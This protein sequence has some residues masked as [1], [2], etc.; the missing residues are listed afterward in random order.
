MNLEESKDK[1]WIVE[2]IP[3]ELKAL[4]IWVGFKFIPQAG[5]K[6]KKEPINVATG[7]HAKSNDPK[8]W[9]TFD[10][11][12]AKTDMLKLNAIGIA[13]I[14][15]YIVCDIDHSVRDR[16]PSLLAKKIISAFPSYAEFSPSKTGIH[17]VG[18]GKI[19]R[20]RKFTT[21]DVEMY[22][23]TRFFTFTGDLVPGCSSEIREV[24]ISK[25]YDE[26]VALDDANKK[27]DSLFKRIKKSNDN[28]Q[29]FTL[30]EGK[31]QELYPSQSEADLAFCNKLAFWTGKDPEFMESLFR[32]SGLM[33]TKWDEKHFSD[34]RTYGQSLI[35][36][37]IQDTA[38][39]F[40]ESK[41][42]KQK[43][44]TQGEII[45]RDCEETITE[46]LRDQQGNPYVVLPFDK[47]LEVCTTSS[48]RFRNCF[49]IRYRQNYGHPP[50]NEALKQAR[51][52]VEAK[53]ENGRQVELYNR[54]GWHN[55]AIYYDL[56]TYD[57][58]GVAITKDGWEIVCLPPI[59]KRYPHQAEQALPIKG[60]DP[61]K[62]MDFCNMN[63]DDA[64]LFMTV[65]ASFFIPD[66]PHVI[67]AQVGEQGTG[68]SNNSRMIKSLCDPSKVMSISP[69]KDLEQAQ[70]IAD[71]H[72]VNN[73]DNLSRISEWFSDFLCRAVTGEGDMKRS[74]YTNDEEFIRTYRR[75]FVLNGI[76]SSVC[77]PDLL[78][79]SVIFDI[80]VLKE[81]RPEKQIADEW[82][83][84][85]PGILGGFFTA[86]SNAMAVIHSVSGHERF[87]MSDFAKWGAVLAEALGYSRD[88]FFKKYQESVDHKWEDTAE[89]STFAQRLAYLVESNSGEW[90]GSATTLL[91]SIQSESGFDKTIPSNP[92]ALGAELM[93]I[94]PV[95]RSI[96]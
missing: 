2:N 68:K 46:F 79:R 35:E 77:R 12:V 8:T 14:E 17:L 56:T 94:A 27:K 95:M 43:K 7:G 75:C 55:S 40:G 45:T 96:G 18:K 61:R 76:G 44:L 15:P 1:K 59:F 71:K 72:W 36:K 70:M 37:A 62:L 39:E 4:P 78:D 93:R 47:H 13:V 73:F 5:K 48:S 10:E 84:S 53:C 24:D 3:Q 60:G 90:I 49:A 92:R 63:K 26:L 74:L 6:P 33:R 19:P 20:D 22:S 57:W 66:I 86:I 42:A 89:E 65:V 38:N 64:C 80:P 91:K 50:G 32:K 31:W 16:I 51:I 30:Y 85:L 58:R 23:G 34:G 52:Q 69:P 67:P 11:V 88:E 25:L 83:A 54:V 87:R 28:E 81:T 41:H 29:F 82:K 21:L 9:R